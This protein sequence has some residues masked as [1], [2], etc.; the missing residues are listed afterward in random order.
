MWLAAD[1]ATDNQGSLAAYTGLGKRLAVFL[2]HLHTDTGHILRRLDQV[3]NVD[4]IRGI[5]RVVQVPLDMVHDFL[6]GGQ[7]SRR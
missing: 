5:V 1:L 6:G 7:V 4:Q 3:A 2:L